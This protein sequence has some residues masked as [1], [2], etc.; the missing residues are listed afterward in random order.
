[1]DAP[2]FLAVQCAHHGKHMPGGREI[3]E[4]IEMAPEHDLGC[5]SRALERPPEGGFCW[6]HGA[7]IEQ[8]H[9]G[10]V[11]A[12]HFVQR[13]CRFARVAADASRDEIDLRRFLFERG[14]ELASEDMQVFLGDGEVTGVAA[15][16]A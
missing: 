10:F 9:T 7:G 6:C 14:V 3:G 16:E 2:H 11:A 12:A 4:S 13:Q 5:R 8:P 15:R 1:M